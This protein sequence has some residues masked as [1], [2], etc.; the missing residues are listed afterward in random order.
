MKAVATTEL[1]K[2]LDQL[3]AEVEDDS[4][5]TLLSSSSGRQAVLVP[6]ADFNSWKETMYLLSS[7]ANAEHLRRALAEAEAGKVVEKELI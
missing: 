2:S 5:P 3:I 4:E 6:L 1:G 7:P